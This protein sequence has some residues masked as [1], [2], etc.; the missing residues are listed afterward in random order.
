M[1]NYYKDMN[2]GEIRLFFVG[3]AIL[4]VIV[5]STSTIEKSLKKIEK[6]NDAAIELLEEI[7]DKR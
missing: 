2:M 6:Q 5:I 4:I 1:V 3:I 7:R